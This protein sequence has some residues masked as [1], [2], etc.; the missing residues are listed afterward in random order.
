MQRGHRRPAS[1][2]SAPRCRSDQLRLSA[3]KTWAV[4]AGSLL[5]PFTLENVS[6]ATCRVAAW[7]TVRLID[8]AGRAVPTRTFRYTYSNRV[9]VPFRVVVVRPGRAASFNYFAA[10]WNAGA[11]RACP[12][13]RKV[14]VRLPAQRRWLSVVLEIPACGTLYVDP[15]V[16]G[17]TDDRWGGVGIQH[18]AHP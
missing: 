11:N 14:R 5:E 9:K 16:A 10:D 17:P 6:H 13:A 8:A 1:A 12:N 7:P 18:F 4:A 15:F 3:P 2:A